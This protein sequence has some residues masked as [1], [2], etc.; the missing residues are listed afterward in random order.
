MEIQYEQRNRGS[1]DSGE[2]TLT[3]FIPS[4]DVGKL[5]GKFIRYT[6]NTVAV[7]TTVL[8]HVHVCGWLAYY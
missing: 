3:L 2:Q 8:V 7:D 4:A 5:I 1:R 6:H